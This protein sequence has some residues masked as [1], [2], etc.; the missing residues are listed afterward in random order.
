MFR[1]HLAIGIFLVLLFLPM[2]SYKISFVILVLIFTLFPDIDMSQSYLG[3]HKILRPLQWMVKHR[4][5]FHSFTLAVGVAI[6]LALFYP[7]S[8]LPFFLGYSGHLIGDALTSEGIR[9]WWPFKNEIKWS[10]RTGGRRE[11]VGLFV[12]MILNIILLVRLLI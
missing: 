4:G 1:T 7:I 3:K 6:L 11:K 2:V 10:I 5:F 12:I 8:A 9:P